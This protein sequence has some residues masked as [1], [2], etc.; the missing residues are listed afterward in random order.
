MSNINNIFHNMILSET[1][2]KSIQNARHNKERN[3]M[4]RAARAKI[5]QG[6]DRNN[7]RSGERAIWELMQN[8]RDLSQHAIIKISLKD[9]SITFSHQGE[10]F[11]LDSLS[12]LI[13]Q[14]STKH[15]GEDEVGQYGTGFMTTHVFNRK[16]Y[17]SG[18]CRIDFEDSQM[19]VPLPSGFC[20]DRSSDNEE[21]FTT[22]MNTELI[23]VENLISM[24]GKEESNAWTSFKYLL[25]PEKVEKVAHQLDTTTRLMPFVLVFNDRIEECTIEDDK[26]TTVYSK[27]G[28]RV[29]EPLSYSDSYCKVAT[30]IRIVKNGKADNITIISLELKNGN[31]R[32][33]IPP[34]PI[35]LDDADS[36]PSQF[37]FFP[38]LGTESFGTNFI[39]HSCRLFPTEPRNSYLL[40]QEN[41]GLISKYKSNEEVLDEMFDMLFLYYQ[42]NTA[43]QNLP[44][45]F[46]KV[47]FVYK[48]EDQTTKSF[49]EKLQKKF[50]EEFVKWKMIP[51]DIGYLSI[52]NDYPFAVLDYD[53]YSELDEEQLK[54]YIPIVSK[55][56]SQFLTVPNTDI[57][58]WSKVVY[59]WDPQKNEYYVELSKI[60][61][62][63]KTKD[64]DLHTFLLLLK[65]LGDTGSDLLSSKDLIPNREGVLKKSTELRNGI[66]ISDALYSI[67]KPILGKEVDKIV[68]PK[69]SDI[70][71]LVEYTR[72]NLRNEIKSAIDDLRKQS[73]EFTDISESQLKLLE[74]LIDTGIIDK[75]ISYCSAFTTLGNTS[76]RAQLMP[77]ISQLYG[78]VNYQP[79]EIPSI[80]SDEPDLYLSSFNYLLDYTML[81]L[82]L[83]TSS[84]LKGETQGINNKSLLC[85]FVTSFTKSQ[86]TQRLK[87]LDEY[88]IIPNQLGEVKKFKSLKKN[89]SIDSELQSLYQNIFGKDLKEF[90]VDDDFVSLCPFEE[91]RPEDVGDKIEKGLKARNYEGTDIIWIINNLNRGRWVD[92]FPN[93]YAQREELYYSHGSQ[94][95]KEA[96]FK[97][98]MQGSDRIKRMAELVGSENFESIISKAEDLFHREQERN[99]QFFFTFAIGK[100]IEDDIRN[101]VNRELTCE[102]L[103]N[104]DTIS[105]DDIQYGQDIVISYKGI[106]LY[107]LECKA[108]WNFDDPAHM[109]SLQIKKAVKESK[110][111]A[112]CCVDC[113]LE[114]GCKVPSDATKEV[115][116][117]AHLDI[118]AHTHVHTNIGSLLSSTVNPVIRHEDDETIKDDSNIRIHGSFTCNIPKKVFVNDGTTFNEFMLQLKSLLKQMVDSIS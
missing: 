111:Y 8:A 40:P 38:M 71:K 49:Y 104:K 57:V 102:H 99:R 18:D 41:D 97:I 65:D 112:L 55:Y 16:V 95:D 83:K 33:I 3:E 75:L 72:A 107:Y 14:Q 114:T 81:M 58:E 31:D 15:E 66:N 39:F 100:F 17:I 85:E 30:T 79:I 2:K 63:I 78:R 117:A 47:N 37:M 59:G 86:D 27:V 61:E 56:I 116:A 48:G 19:Y 96:L 108:K 53:I 24:D 76:Y 60:C 69:Y 118:L 70:L 110:H 91:Y 67:A 6:I 73:L 62:N 68:D 82:S 26:I 109:S 36:I 5:I 45:C 13:K 43:Q 94:E 12:N 29:V 80:E 11:N 44:L 88:G 106:P 54:A 20:L 21:T 87:K 98:Q 115:V 35:G 52:K 46:A 7:N 64:D 77:I 93:I 9:N 28:E 4:L 25:A 1:Q 89:S 101:E 23:S 34:L 84:W 103:E 32:I 92:F 74:D 90:F 113:T 50:S 22:E 42:N 51:T 10:P 105:T